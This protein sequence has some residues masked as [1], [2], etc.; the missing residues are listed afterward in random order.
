MS[1]N[2]VIE[3][4]ETIIK[5]D[6]EEHKMLLA[7]TTTELHSYREGR[8]SEIKRKKHYASL[9]GGGVYNDD[10]LRRS[11]DDIA[12]NIRHM[13]DKAEAAEAKITHHKLIV[14]TLAQQLVDQNKALDMLAEYRRKNPSASGS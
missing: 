10:S 7:R 6:L 11:M 8:A 2:V 5:R 9:V 3:G 12:I 14:D 13:S 1:D 4:L